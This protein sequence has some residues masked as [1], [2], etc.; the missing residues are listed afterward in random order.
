MNEPRMAA[1]SAP[2][3]LIL[4]VDEVEETRDAIEKLLTADGY[5]VNASRDEQGAI[6][7]GRRQNPEL[8]LMSRGGQS[9]VVAT[10]RRIRDHACL[11]TTIPLVIF[12]AETIAEGTEMDIGENTHLIHPDNFDQLRRLVRRLLRQV[13]YSS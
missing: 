2:R 12:N 5:R 8:I 6:N 1:K 3:E 10:V 4:V 9:D 7:S 13:S 11:D